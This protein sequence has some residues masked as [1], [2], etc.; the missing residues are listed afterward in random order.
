P[1]V[2]HSPAVAGRRP[3]PFPVPPSTPG[4][5]DDDRRMTAA[6]LGLAI[7]TLGVLGLALPGPTSDAHSPVSRPVLAAPTPSAGLPSAR[8]PS[9]RL[10][11]VP[12]REAVWPMHP[13]PEVAAEFD[14]PA[15]D[16][17]S[18]HR[19]VDLAGSPGQVVRAA[20]PGTVIFAG[21][22][23]GRG[24]VVV[25]HGATRTTYEPVRATV[26]LGSPVGAGE[27]IGRLQLAGSHCAP[28][29]CLH[30]GL[31]EG[32]TYLDP[33]TLVGAGPVRLLP[34]FTDLPYSQSGGAVSPPLPRRRDGPARPVGGPGGRPAA[35]GPW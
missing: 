28:S 21:M 7:L 16:Y 24:V 6:P 15:S 13:R 20:A 3:Q 4:F 17:G 25:G 34:L 32:D 14:P 29:A 35:G 12:T 23:A 31:L 19:G 27:E 26:A 33:L 18:G 2:A 30:W 11:S 10:P 8:L 9:A 1:V 5:A 22:I